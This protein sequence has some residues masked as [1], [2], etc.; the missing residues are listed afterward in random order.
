MVDVTD[1]VVTLD[2]L[3]S[4]DVP[5]ERV[6]NGAIEADLQGAVVLGWTQDGDFYFASSIADGGNCMWLLEKAKLLLLTI[7]DED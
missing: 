6:L 7:E 4:L 3:T 1:N 5:P 2:I